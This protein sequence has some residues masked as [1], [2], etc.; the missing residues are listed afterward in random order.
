MRLAAFAT[1][2]CR[3]LCAANSPRAR[4]FQP[5]RQR[6]PAAARKRTE[7]SPSEPPRQLQLG[8]SVAHQSPFAG[9]KRGR[10]VSQLHQSATTNKTKRAHTTAGELD[11]AGS[12]KLQATSARSNDASKTRGENQHRELKSKRSRLEHGRPSGPKTRLGRQ[13]VRLRAPASRVSCAGRVC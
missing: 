3:F 9:L 4:N 10:K 7:R 13:L 6:P 11:W 2:V 12:R 8:A 1:R 5:R